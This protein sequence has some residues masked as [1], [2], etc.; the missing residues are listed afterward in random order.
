MLTCP[1][2]LALLLAAAS[3]L[4]AVPRLRLSSTV[5]GPVSVAQG[6]AVQAQ[7]LEVFS[8]AASG[9]NA[10]TSN[11]R[12]TF[13]STAPWV[14][15]SAAALRNCSKREGQCIPVR[16][17]FATQPL[18]PGPYSASISVNDP[19]A[20]DAPQNLLVLINVGGGVPSSL[21]LFVAPD[22]STDEVRFATNGRLAS[23]V[24]TDRGGEWLSL[25]QAGAG[26]FEFVVPYR[27]AARHL[28]G[29]A[30]GT[31][32]GTIRVTGSQFGP[33]NKNITV[34]LRVT[35]QPIASLPQASLRLRLAQNSTKL[36]QT[37]RVANRGQGTLTISGVTATT[38]AGGSWL[39]AEQVQNMN[40][41]TIT[42]DS[43]NT[44]PGVYRGTVAVASN[45]A[46]SP[47]NLP[48]ELEVLAQ[49]PPSIRYQGVIENAVFQ[50]G[51][52][53]AAGGIVAAFGEQLSFEQPQSNQS[54]P[55]PQQLGGARV[56][57]NDQPAPIFFTSYGQVNFQIPYDTAPGEATVRIDRGSQRGNSV[58]VNVVPASPK[59]LRLRLRDAGINIAEARDF[60]GIAVNAAD[61]TFS[62]PRSLGI[63]NSRPSRRGEAII[64]YGLGMGQTN[65]PVRAG[66][67][68][69]TEPLAAVASSSAV[70]YF[71]ALALNTG[72]PQDA[73][74][75]GLTPGLVGL[76]Q[77]NVV[78][79]EQSPSG[80]V[81]VRIQFDTVASEYAL[82]AVE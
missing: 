45:A 32:S 34:A 26:S 47:L 8:V 9:I 70:V 65:P 19:T 7:E 41:V 15:A 62:L 14:S 3:T 29:M 81:A 39:A 42:A 50:E 37:L 12:L 10:E 27:V 69:P 28:P 80:D 16:L 75:A 73:L 48:V 66:E 71:G 67:A 55:L 77:V 58:T 64:L 79:P 57:V 74:F 23:A 22:G 38:S 52:V 24:T 78:V 63:P 36:S 72:A 33:D 1:S 46:N 60:F 59:I 53:V 6:A 68:A 13:S 35:P 56:F 11:L 5:V 18:Q 25:T 49:G 17:T 82:I 61:N 54:L 4:C 51:D 40:F 31:Y 21:N 2:R 44:P 43:T 20:L 30:E 76:Y